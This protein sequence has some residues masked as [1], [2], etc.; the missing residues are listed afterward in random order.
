MSG[1]YRL[2]ALLLL[3]FA[4][5]AATAVAQPS[6]APAAATPVYGYTF[7]PSP[8]TGTPGIFEVQLN[9]NNLHGGGPIDIRVTTTPDV[10]KVTTGNGS[11]SGALTQSAPG[12]FTSEARLPHVGADL[13]VKHIK[14]HFTATTA[15]GVSVSVDVPVTYK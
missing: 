2:C 9:S 4:G 8:Q 7:T 15:A 3:V 13:V 11:K 1:A 10:V 12:I 14:L 5:L 6:P